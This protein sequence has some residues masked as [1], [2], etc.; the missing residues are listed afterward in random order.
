MS[1][2]VSE[3]VSEGER[4]WRSE[5]AALRNDP[6]FL[7]GYSI[8]NGGTVRPGGRAVLGHWLAS[9]DCPKLEWARHVRGNDA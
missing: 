3:G 5:N 2:G 9:D 6:C 7:G 8:L 4:N 1:E